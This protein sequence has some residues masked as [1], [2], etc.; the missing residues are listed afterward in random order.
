[1]PAP[2]RTSRAAIVTAARE[3]LEADGLDALS[4]QAV[5]DRV[6]V[7]APSLYKHV[8]DRVSLLRAVTESVSRDL[9]AALRVD[10]PAKDPRDDLRAIARRYR[11]FVQ[12]AP[13]GYG[14]LFARLGSDALPDPAVL[15][16]LG[17]PIV[18]TTTRLVGPDGAL[19][20]ARTFV[21]WAHGFASLELAGGFRLGGDLDAAYADGVEL[22]LAGISAPARRS[23]S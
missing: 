17:E 6:G 23:A 1:M 20:A 2:A 8:A 13:V 9:A 14:L 12:G 19:A 3:I 18:T 15:A 5:A 10:R 21:A 11:A 16:A 4:M 22:I 7:R